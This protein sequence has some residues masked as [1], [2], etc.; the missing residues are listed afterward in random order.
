MFVFNFYIVT[1]FTE[2]ADVS[3][4]QVRLWVKSAHHL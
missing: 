4:Y 3:D 2:N 1:I